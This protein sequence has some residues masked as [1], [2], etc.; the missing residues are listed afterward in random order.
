MSRRQIL[1]RLPRQWPLVAAVVSLAMLVIAHA[2]EVFGGLVPCALCLRQREVYWTALVLGL[3][4]LVLSRFWRPALTR[5]LTCG[6]LAL[7]FLFGAGLAAYHAGVEWTWWPGPTTCSGGGAVS[8]DAMAD[9]LGGKKIRGPSCDRA[10]WVFLGLSMAGW[11]SLASLA[12][13]V[14]SLQAFRRSAAD[15]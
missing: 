13:S 9:L 5:R 15:A 7:V 4:G 6:L 8:A 3:G 14:I 2:S 10:A 12:L 11:N 1:D